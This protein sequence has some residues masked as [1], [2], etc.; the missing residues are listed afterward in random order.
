MKNGKYALIIAIFAL[1]CYPIN[2]VV[3][4]GLIVTAMTYAIVKAKDWEVIIKVAQPSLMIMSL[5]SLRAIIAIVIN[6]I[7]NIAMLKD[8]YYS[9]KL[10]ENITN[11]NRIFA[12]IL[13]VIAF[14]YIVVSIVFFMMNKDVPLYGKLARKII[15]DKKEND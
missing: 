4:I 8:N 13:L 3:C 14:V 5:Y 1:I 11:F 12:M 2:D 7:S 6:S 10:Y 9:S 15:G